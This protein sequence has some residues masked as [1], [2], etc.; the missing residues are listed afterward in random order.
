M[1]IVVAKR[2]QSVPL[3][4][5]TGDSQILNLTRNPPQISNT[6]HSDSL[7]LIILCK[8]NSFF[9]PLSLLFWTIICLFFFS[10]ATFLHRG[11]L[12]AVV[13]IGHLS[14][15]GKLLVQIQNYQYL[16]LNTDRRPITF[17]SHLRV[18]PSLDLSLM[19]CGD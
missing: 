9:S 10:S 7:T 6:K 14:F 11:H 1:E 18:I 4:R 19:R 2:N 16:K 13:K 15:N 17:Q 3:W 8:F 5:Y 12:G